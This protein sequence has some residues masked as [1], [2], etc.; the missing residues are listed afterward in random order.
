ME[1]PRIDEHRPELA[2]QIGADEDVLA[3]ARGE[4]ADG[5]RHDLVRVGDL[6]LQDLAAR[7][8][9][10][11]LREVAA[12]HRRAADVV[13]VAPRRLDLADRARQRLGARED[14]HQHVVEVVRDPAGQ[15]SEVVEL[16]RFENARLHPPALR[17]VA[18][19]RRARGHAAVAAGDG[20][21][22]DLREEARPVLPHAPRLRLAA[23][24][25][26]HRRQLAPQRLEVALRL[27]MEQRDRPADD[28]LG[29]VAG[30]PLRAGVP[31]RHAAVEIDDDDRVVA[32]RVDQEAHPFFALPE[33][34]VLRAVPVQRELDRAPQ[35]SL[36]ERLQHVA[37][38]R[39]AGRA[40]HRGIVGVRGEEDDRDVE[41]LADDAAG[42]DAVHRTAEA[43]VHQHQV[44]T[45]FRRGV[46]RGGPGVDHRGHRVAEAAQRGRDVHGHDGLVLDHQ[47]A[48]VSHA[49]CAPCGS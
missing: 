47:D 42:L 26:H 35:L 38:R 31:T 1:L 8:R 10:E 4:Q 30:H 14:H 36:V 7:G 39:G 23:A 27:R 28:L 11:L 41:A 43:D 18:H 46:D 16:L 32:H 21:A 40:L 22:D 3:D 15:A 45:R 17:H 25:L 48:R 9:E 5:R 37:V 13:D 34:V 44:G 33:R 2:L 6:R 29:G 49:P 19:H 24:A 20:R 12:P